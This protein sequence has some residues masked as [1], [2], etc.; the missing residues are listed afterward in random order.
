M[1]DNGKENGNYY[2]GL[3]RGY[4]GIMGF[5]WAVVK[6]MVPFWILIIIRHLVLRVPQ[7]GPKS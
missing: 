4:I 1:G 6:L 2:N 5:I 3:H 7:K